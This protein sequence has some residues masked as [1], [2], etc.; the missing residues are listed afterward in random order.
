MA[1]NK[2]Q[3]YIALSAEQ[4]NTQIADAQLKLKKLK[5]AHAITPV[6]NPM[7]IRVTRKEIAR[8]KTALASK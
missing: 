8:M 6:E 3:D 4:L 5:F 7:S 1:K 2:K